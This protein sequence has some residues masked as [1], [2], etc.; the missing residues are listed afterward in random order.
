MKKYFAY[1]NQYLNGWRYWL[2][3]Y[4]QSI[5]IVF[6]GLGLYLIGVTI[7]SR[8]RSLSHSNNEAIA[9]TVICI[10]AVLLV[11]A[12]QFSQPENYLIYLLILN[13]PH[14]YLWFS[15]GQ[16]PLYQKSNNDNLEKSPKDEIDEI[17][18]SDIDFTI[19]NEVLDS[20]NETESVAEILTTKTNSENTISES[21]SSIRETVIDSDWISGVED[22]EESVDDKFEN[23]ELINLNW[24]YGLNK[25]YTQSNKNEN[26]YIPFNAPVYWKDTED[27]V[28]S[29]IIRTDSK[30][31]A[32]KIIDGIIK[33]NGNTQGF[34]SIDS[35][36]NWDYLFKGDLFFIGYLIDQGCVRINKPKSRFV[37]VGNTEAKFGIS[38]FDNSIRSL[39]KGLEKILYCDGEGPGDKRLCVTERDGKCSF[40]FAYYDSVEDSLSLFKSIVSNY[41]KSH[42]VFHLSVEELDQIITSDGLG[43]GLEYRNEDFGLVL[44]R[45]NVK[46]KFYITPPGGFFGDAFNFND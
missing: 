5:L 24:I 16:K 35:E 29:I 12:I 25:I 31:E 42:D 34:E 41:N 23:L 26:L 3:M 32:E 14:F 15:N 8:A 22:P 40:V 11:L 36:D 17:D 6:F 4:L 21:E 13:I 19:K 44:I 18:N 10:I 27:E 7:Y 33:A 30:E 39:V 38:I 1:N 46:Y 45:E 2:R 9:I 28:E 37:N 43:S 20:T